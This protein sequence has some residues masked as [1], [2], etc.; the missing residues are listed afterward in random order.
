MPPTQPTFLAPVLV[1]PADCAQSQLSYEHSFPAASS[2]LAQCS[3][4]LP[5]VGVFASALLASSMVHR[6][7]GA[8][9]GVQALG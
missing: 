7:A 3:Q 6:L 8:S 5:H 2:D 1:C 4:E 9:E